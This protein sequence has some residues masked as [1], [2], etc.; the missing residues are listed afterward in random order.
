MICLERKWK[1]KNDLIT[2]ISENCPRKLFTDIGKLEQILKTFIDA[3]KFTPEKERF[4]YAFR[5]RPNDFTSETLTKLKSDEILSVYI[6]DNGIGISE[7]NKVIS[8]IPAG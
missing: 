2:T 6:Q 8:N 5:F 1:K 4:L 7:D 3:L